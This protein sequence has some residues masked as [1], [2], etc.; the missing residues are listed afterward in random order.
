[1]VLQTADILPAPFAWV[2][3]S[4]GQVTL[5]SYREKKRKY[6]IPGF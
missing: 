5:E 1:M 4:A 2:E 3:I 6:N